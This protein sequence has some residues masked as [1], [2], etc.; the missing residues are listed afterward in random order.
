MR[1]FRHENRERNHATRRV[2][3]YFELAYTFVDFTA[4]LCFVVGSL[5]FF[6][7][8]L[9]TPAIWLFLVGSLLFA[10]KPTL[11]LTREIKLLRMGQLDSLADRRP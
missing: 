4:A 10:A 3:A 11:R 9:E 2:Y 1:L 8:A 5:L 7:K 6:W